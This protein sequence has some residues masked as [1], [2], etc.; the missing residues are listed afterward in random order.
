MKGRELERVV[1]NG[2][3]YPILF[4]ERVIVR[5]MRMYNIN[6]QAKDFNKVLKDAMMDFDKM[7]DLIYLAIKHACKMEGEKF[8]MSSDDFG[9]ELDIDEA[10]R[11]RCLELY[12][13]SQDTGV[14]AVEE[15]KS[16]KKKVA[17]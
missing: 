12:A 9:F 15:P 11:D 14:E 8:E 10:G 1:V 3:E 17:L 7:Y 16:G 4:C 6:M 2:T 5:W 13:K